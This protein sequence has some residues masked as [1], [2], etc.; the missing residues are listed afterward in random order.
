M[1]PK[2]VHSFFFDFLGTQNMVRVI[3]GKINKMIWGEPKINSS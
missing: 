2:P 3:K 1:F